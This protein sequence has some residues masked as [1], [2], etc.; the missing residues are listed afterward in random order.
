[1]NIRLFIATVMI[2]FCATAVFAQSSNDYQ[3]WE[4][5]GGYSHARVQSTI[6]NEVVP[7]RPVS[8]IGIRL[9]ARVPHSLVLSSRRSFVT[10]A[11]STAWMH[12]WLS[13][14]RGTS[15]L[16]ATSP[17]ISSWTDFSI[18]FRRRL[19]ICAAFVPPRFSLLI[20]RLIRN[21][22]LSALPIF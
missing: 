14:S 19:L 3:K 8:S 5:S 18:L 22:K 21:R 6:G 10:E 12:R 11:G 2:A 15:V 9:A 16:K 17:A 20:R 13:T 7:Q 4:V 1:M